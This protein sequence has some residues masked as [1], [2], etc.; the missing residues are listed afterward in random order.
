MITDRDA[1]YEKRLK[2]SIPYVEGDELK[3]FEKHYGSAYH[4]DID[5]RTEKGV[6]F[7]EDNTDGDFFNN[8]DEMTKDFKVRQFILRGRYEG[9]LAK[10]FFVDLDKEGKDR[11]ATGIDG[12]YESNTVALIEIF[13]KHYGNSV[14]KK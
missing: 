11:V 13:K 6:V 12:Y 7:V 2:D 9:K 14:G 8:I 10:Y 4:K 5:I 1:D 3:F